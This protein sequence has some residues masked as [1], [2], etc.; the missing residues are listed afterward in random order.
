[1]VAPLHT[2]TS[3]N[4]LGVTFDNSLEWSAHVA[5]GYIFICIGLIPIEKIYHLESLK[6]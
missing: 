6:C 5:A 4:I 3:K 2:V 1:M